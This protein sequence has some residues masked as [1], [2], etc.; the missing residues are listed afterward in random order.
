MRG[1]KSAAIAH[2]KPD[3]AMLNK[4]NAVKEKKASKKNSDAPKRPAGAFFIFMEEFRKSYKEN[5]PD[6]KACSAVG[7][8]GGEKWKLM[9]TA[10][11]CPYVEMALKRKVEYEKAVE[12]Y[13]IKLSDNGED[14]KNEESEKSISYVHEESGENDSS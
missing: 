1:P 4:R 9:S 11:K 6:V 3:T 10:E 13:K 7:K 12:A 5:Y 14:E 2:K 8:A